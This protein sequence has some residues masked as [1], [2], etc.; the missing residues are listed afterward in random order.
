MHRIQAGP[1]YPL[2][3]I[4]QTRALE[5]RLIASLA[6][7]T[8]MQRAGLA[9]AKLALAIEP[10]AQTIWLACG[11]GDNAGDGLE[12]AAKLQ[13]WGKNCF[14]TWTGSINKMSPDAAHAL[15]R[16]RDAGVGWC[17]EAQKVPVK[18]DL[19]IDALLGLGSQDRPIQGAIAKLIGQLNELQAPTL[20]IDTPS[21]LNP[22]TGAALGQHVQA[23][24]TLSLLTLKPGQFT[25][26]GRDACGSIWL[27]TLLAHD[28]AK[29]SLFIEPAARLLASPPQTAR[30]HASH[31]GSYGD[32]AVIGGAHGMTGAATL[33]GTAALHAGAGRV[34]VCLLDEVGLQ[35]GSDQ[36]ELM[37][38]AANTLALQSMVVVCGCGGAQTVAEQL[39]QVLALPSSLVL[40]AD[41]LNAIAQNSIWQDALQSRQARYAATVLTPHPLEAARLLGC[42]TADVQRDRLAAAQALSHRFGC[43]VVL[44]GSGSIIAAPAQTPQINLTGNAR[45]ASAGTGD[46]LA[47]LIGARL[48]QGLPAFEA[49]CAS[50]YQHGQLADTWPE[51][52]ALTAGRLAKALSF[53]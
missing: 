38:R 30:Y 10:H 13:S 52:T 21:G 29:Q 1:V 40:D 36:P 50:V 33:A 16:A 19:C 37:Y 48:A 2:Y 53:I 28:Q 46:V 24:H 3:S 6:P 4:S 7:Y 51:Q 39:D 41:A 8:L 23:Q 49:A 34:F 5:T 31:K 32:V 9:V 47:G 22:Q 26:Q 11:P 12:A 44:K 27:E 14:V 20:A 15:Q 45:L 35:G 42:Q 18:I 43:C 25:A 17:E